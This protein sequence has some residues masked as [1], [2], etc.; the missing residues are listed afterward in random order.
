M[1]WHNRAVTDADGT[2]QSIFSKFQDITERKNRKMKLEEHET[3]IEALSDAVY[4]LNQEGQFTYVNDELVELVGYDRETIIGNT[5]SLIKD[6]EA[7]EQAE[8]QLGRLLSSEGPDAVTFEVTIQ[9]CDGDPIVCEDH[10]G[11]LPYEGDQFDGSV[12]T[13]RDI[14]ARKERERELQRTND[15]M[16]NMEQLADAGAWEYDSE[17][18]S[19]TV[20]DGARRL[21]GLDPDENLT[22]EAA[23]ETIHPDDRDRVRDRADACLETGDPYEVEVRYT[24]PDS[25]QRWLSIKGERVSGGDANSVVRGY[26]RDTTE[27][28]YQRDLK[29]FWTIFDEVPDSAERTRTDSELEPDYAPQ[30]GGTSK[31]RLEYFID[32]Y[33]PIIGILNRVSSRDEAEQTVCDLLTATRAYDVAWTAEYTPEMSE[34]TPHFRSDPDETI[35]EDWTSPPMDPAAEQTLPRVAAETGAVQVVT[36]NQP[37]DAYDAWREH[38][39]EHGFSGC[40]LVPLVYRDQTY[41]LIGVYTTRQSPFGNREQVLL[42]TVGD[43]LGRLIHELFTEKQLHTDTVYELTFRSTDSQSLFVRTATDLGCTIEVTDSIPASEEAFI[44]YV[45]IS[46]APV[47]E[48]IEAVE[49]NNVARQVRSIRRS[50]D[51]PGGEVELKLSRQSIAGALINLGAVVIAD[52]VTDDHAEVVCEV[53]VGEDISSLVARIMDSFPETTLVSKCEYDRSVDSVRQTS[54]SLLADVFSEE[55]TE[56]QRQ[57]LEASVHAGYFESPRRSTATEIADALSLTQ[58]TVSRHLRDAQRKLFE[59]MFEQV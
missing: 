1:E 26:I 4:V 41:G 28:H 32:T 51:P 2:V 48:F 6:A 35:A 37:V 43:R 23:L 5:P 53:P 22:L 57:T 12:G 27:Q 52:T 15:L 59:R 11:V 9:P 8:H 30:T 10:M 16:T 3:I 42:Q 55:L 46:G 31:K 45:S 39:L 24:T 18:E 50:D 19:L 34:L 44:H 14:T 40:A 13:L 17:T 7:V 54:E 20:T 25:A 56:R 47:D 29:R 21:H 58:P 49:D 33:Q 36:K 38:T